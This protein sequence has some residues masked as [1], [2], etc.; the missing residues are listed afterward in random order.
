MDQRGKARGRT[1]ERWW[2][3]TSAHRPVRGRRSLLRTVPAH[4]RRPSSAPGGSS[5]EGQRARRP[6]HPHRVHAARTAA[7]R[8]PLLR[9]RAA[10]TAAS[11]HPPVPLL[12]CRTRQAEVSHSRTRRSPTPRRLGYRLSRHQAG[13]RGSPAAPATRNPRPPSPIPADRRLR[14]ANHQHPHHH[15]TADL[16]QTDRR[17]R[18]RPADQAC[19]WAN[20]QD[21]HHATSRAERRRRC[22]AATPGHRS[23]GRRGPAAAPKRQGSG[24][25][26]RN[27][28]GRRRAGCRGSRRAPPGAGSGQ[29][30]ASRLRAAGWSSR[31]LRGCPGRV[32][33]HP[34]GRSGMGRSVR[35]RAVRGQWR[36]RSRATAPRLRPR[37]CT[38]PRVGPTG[39]R[40]CG[41]GPRPASC[42]CSTTDRRGGQRDAGAKVR[43]ILGQDWAPYQHKRPY[44]R[45]SQVTWTS[46][47]C[48]P[49]APSGATG[50]RCSVWVYP[51]ASVARTSS[52]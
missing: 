50:A 16:P 15:P 1:G 7:S 48:Q 46:I 47:V 18:H 9:V 35:S 6:D 33:R 23:S 19:W 37:G 30:G 29:A 32:R 24:H 28:T 41:R 21:P 8:H 39:R 31:G 25:R 2:A 20:H 11:R 22:P 36:S 38:A 40:T 27:G 52:V 5:P 17:H 49:V 3:R 43:K 44:Q 14:R 4:R 10:R 26:A 13:R 45:T 42:H 51:A 12:S 34:W